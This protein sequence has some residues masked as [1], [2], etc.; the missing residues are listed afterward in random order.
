MKRIH[1]L[2]L[3]LA[4]LPVTGLA[5]TVIVFAAGSLRSPLTAIAS[6][7][8][9]TGAYKVSATY[10]ASGLLRDRIAGGEAADVFAS[11]NMEH[12]QSLTAKGWSAKT[13]AF[14]RNE[15]CILAS[16]RVPVTTQ[17]ALD[18]M[19]DPQWKLGTSTP[20]ADPSGDYAWDVFRRAEAMRPG[21]LAILEGKARKLTGGP[22]S[23][24]PPADRSVYAMLVAGGEADVFLTYCTNARQAVDEIAGLA[25]V[26]LPDALR[27]GATYGIAVREGAPASA[28]AFADF[29]TSAPGQR[30]LAR[31]GFAPP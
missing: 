6:E 8:E 22:N 5:Q 17:N 20:K 16:K 28:Q 4:V 30:A 1:V 2:V 12:P 31:F 21:A 14:A 15:L 10:G 18:V 27:V 13:V 25:I 29:L 24:A 11:A 7:F 9:K 26:P 19:L 23:P 3:A